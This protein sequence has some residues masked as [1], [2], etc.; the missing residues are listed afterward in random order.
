M[1]ALTANLGN[2]MMVSADRSVVAGERGPF[3]YML[4]S[5]SRHWDRVDVIGTRPATVEQRC[6]FGNVHLHHPTTGKLR[7]AGFIAKTGRALAAERDYTVITSH[8]YNPFYNGLG[9]WRISRA[10]GI[11]YVAEIHHVPGHPR[12]ADL[13]ERFDK[14]ATRAYVRWA[15]SRAAGFRV[16]NGV[17]LPSLLR[18]WGVADERIHVLTSLYLD[19]DIFKP[20]PTPQPA[21]CDLLFVG[22][23]VP[24]KGVL[25]I[26]RALPLLADAG[27]PDLTLRLL[28]RG[29]QQ[30]PI[31]DEARRLGV[32]D[33]ID[34]I[35]W[36]PDAEALAEVYRSAR[37]LVCA[38][39]SEGGP[40]VVPEAM[41]CGTPSAST[42]VGIVS[43]LIDHGRNGLVFDGSA[44]D[45]ATKLQP[46][47]A[48]PTR[49][50]AMRAEL[51]TGDLSR[52]D[53]DTV[54]AG[55]A[56]GLKA[57]AADYRASPPD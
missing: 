53:R 47:L 43:E 10:T 50:A 16:V 38:S 4:E 24:N 46:V 17:E 21:T 18:S 37:V 36:V 40:R 19:L 6:V 26:V 35:D 14:P 33:R 54:I 23:L 45:L 51:A 27:L 30:A 12:P 15:A 29:P 31:L 42:S 52:F 32:F 22:R 57:I 20:A 56:D 9:S 11:P 39:T 55:L 48:D 49:E 5:F 2:V 13:R 1:G 8:D 25:E 3:H 7:Q 41:A 28:G 34:H 44:A